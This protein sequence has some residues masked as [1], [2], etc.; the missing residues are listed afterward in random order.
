MWEL[1]CA[2]LGG[3]A[4]G[5]IGGV[6]LY[7]QIGNPH[8]LW[9]M[10]LAGAEAVAVTI[11]LF[12]IL[13]IT[14]GIYLNLFIIQFILLIL[15]GL[16][17]AL[18]LWE[19]FY[20]LKYQRGIPDWAKYTLLFAWFLG[21]PAASFAFL[22]HLPVT[23]TP[24]W[25]ST[26]LVSIGWG[27]VSGYSGYSYSAFSRQTLR[28]HSHKRTEFIVGLWLLCG[29]FAAAAWLLGPHT[30]QLNEK[31]DTMALFLIATPILFTALPLYPLIVL[32]N[33]RQTRVAFLRSLTKTENLLP[34]RF[35][36]FAYPLPG[37]YRLFKNYSLLRGTPE[38]VK[39]LQKIQLESL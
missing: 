4:W 31:L 13:G 25:G 18:A 26:F 23:E 12:I 14:A 15:G 2:L 29:I 24:V 16:V 22:P 36:T 8:I 32:E 5:F 10:P 30:Q 3:A 39:L 11:L 35:Q 20:R 37:F 33:L 21:I 34:L 7:W 38:T 1:W 28:E 17:L 9:V 19:V 27:F 6:I